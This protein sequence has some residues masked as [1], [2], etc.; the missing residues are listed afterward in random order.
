MLRTPV[1]AAALAVAL[2][3]AA[4]HAQITFAPQVPYAA[5]TQPDGIAFAD[6]NG[7]GR[8]DLAATA[9]APDRVLVRLNTGGG[10]FG[11]AVA[12]PVGAGT[13]AHSL[14]ALNV[15]NDGDMDLVVTLQNTNQVRLLVNT[16]GVLAAG[17]TT[18]V[19]GTEPRQVAVADL[20]GNG[21]MDVVTSNRTSGDVSVLLNSG[22][23]LGAPAP[24]AIG[25]E[26]RGVVLADVDGD[27]RPDIIVAEHDGR[28]VEV[29]LNLPSSPGVFTQGPS[30]SVG[31]QLRPDSVDAKDLDSDGD[32]D[33]V[34]STSG[35]G[36]N[37]A[38]V[39]FNQGA[40]TFGPATNFAAGGANPGAVVAADFDRDGRR[41][42]ALA[43]QDSGN[44]TVLRNLGGGTFAAGIPFAAGSNPQALAAADIDLN[45]ALDL[46]T[47][48][49][50][51]DNLSIFR[52]TS[53]LFADGFESGNTSHWSAV[54]P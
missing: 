25:V 21:F 17:A 15:D 49:Q 10:V 3:T 5:A 13:G 1:L 37:F 23:T 2:T 33:V 28:T 50:S 30:L 36:L 27:L 40:G 7:D 31:A 46:G 29:L 42:L 54:A 35:N 4:A 43:N 32:R 47:A 14:A 39:F 26:P 52:N 38:T 8:P 9:D 44:L 12:I 20:D 6:F 19:G 51:S 45:G 22:G 34:T 48:N 16:G 41:D 24:Y 18:G 11:A 53:I